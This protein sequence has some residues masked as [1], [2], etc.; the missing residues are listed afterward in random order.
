ME[1]CTKVRHWTQSWVTSMGSIST[2]PKVIRSVLILYYDY[3]ITNSMALS[4]SWEAASH[5]AT[6]EFPKILRNPKVLYGVYKSPPHWP[7]ILSQMNPVHTTPSFF[8]ETHLDITLPPTSI[9]S[10]TFHSFSLSHQ[11][12]IYMP[13][14]LMRAT[15][16][17]NLILLG[18]IILIIFG[19]EYKIWHSAL[20]SFFQSA[21]IS[22]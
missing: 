6:H 9:P 3:C 1:P 10:Y 20:Y 17:T 21:T 18:L 13:L 19:D 12:L 15:F 7:P 5:L 2:Q 16:P 8:Y 11:N 14:F 22:P 4:P